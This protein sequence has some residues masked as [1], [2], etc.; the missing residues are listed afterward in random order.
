[1]TVEQ[2]YQLKFPIGEYNPP[3]EINPQHVSDWIQSIESFPKKVKELTQHLT[4]EQKNWRYRPNG[5]KIKQVVHHCADSHI[6]SITRFK[7]AVTE[8][9]PTIRPYYE[10][11]WAELID[12]HDDNLEDSLMLLTGLHNKWVKLLKNFSATDLKKEFIHPEHG[13]KFV[14]D[15]AIGMYAWHC[16]HHLAHIKQGLDAKGKF[17]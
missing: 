2:L 8:D 7:L 1:M 17:D 16:N 5:W 6:N 10:D 14:L 3:K 13:R 4:I 11:R 15:E 12:S 9:N